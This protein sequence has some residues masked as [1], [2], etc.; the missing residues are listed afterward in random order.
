MEEERLDVKY[1]GQDK[2]I[3]QA[4]ADVIVKLPVDVIRFIHAQCVF[5]AVGEGS[6]SVLAEI[7]APKRSQSNV[8]RQPAWIIILYEG[9]NSHWL[10]HV[11]ACEIANAWIR[12]NELDEEPEALASAWGFNPE[13]RKKLTRRDLMTAVLEQAHVIH[14]KYGSGIIRRIDVSGFNQRIL[15]E[16]LNGDY[17]KV[18]SPEEFEWSGRV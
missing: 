10:K 16:D 7:K 13:A 18:K 3:L 15:F 2:S 9:I 14:N 6:P 5:V 11:I 17:H 12:Q 4:V 1:I 8:A